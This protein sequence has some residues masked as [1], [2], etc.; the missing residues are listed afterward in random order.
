MGGASLMVSAMI[1]SDPDP[2][3]YMCLLD[4]VVRAKDHGIDVAHDVAYGA[5]DFESMLPL[6]Y[7]RLCGEYPTDTDENQQVL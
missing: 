3:P 4:L 1:A 2:D 5:G 7:R 6:M